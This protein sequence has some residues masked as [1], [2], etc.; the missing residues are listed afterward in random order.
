MLKVYI[1]INYIA[2]PY[3]LKICTLYIKNMMK[4]SPRMQINA[5]LSC[6]RLSSISCCLFK[7]FSSISCNSGN[8][9]C[10][11]F[12]AVN[13]RSEFRHRFFQSHTLRALS[14]NHVHSTGQPK[15]SHSYPILSINCFKAWTLKLQVTS[16]NERTQQKTSGLRSYISWVMNSVIWLPSF[17]QLTLH[18][19]STFNKDPQLDCI[20]AIDKL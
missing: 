18:H 20:R 19:L 10:V 9:F 4:L 3:T 11:I 1:L 14:D 12:P 6:W 7:C 5:I 13:K 8:L 17:W 2:A 16:N 15:D